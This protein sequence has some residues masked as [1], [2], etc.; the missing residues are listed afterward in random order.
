MQ[1]GCRPPPTGG[2]L[3]LE[4]NVVL[5]VWI[6]QNGQEGPQF[7]VKQVLDV[8]VFGSSFP[9]EDAKAGSCESARVP[10]SAAPGR[11]GRRAAWRPGAM[12]ANG[13]WQW[14]LPGRHHIGRADVWPL[15][16]VRRAAPDC[17]NRKEKGNRDG[18]RRR[19]GL[20]LGP[21]DL[22]HQLGFAGAQHPPELEAAVERVLLRASKHR[23]PCGIS[24][25]T[26]QLVTAEGGVPLPGARAGH[27][28]HGQH[29]LRVEG[30][31]QILTNRL[32]EPESSSRFVRHMSAPLQRRDNM[33]VT[34]RQVVLA[35]VLI[36]LEAVPALA[37]E[38]KV[39]HRD[40]KEAIA[41]AEVS[42]EGD[43][44]S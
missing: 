14:S 6:P 8:G 27:R 35:L 22:L 39:V 34:A 24:V 25:Y 3:S 30:A 11:Q 1:D 37:L 10:V 21:G 16:S 2:K 33:T 12:P 38:G 9:C 19:R 13:C 7:I 26:P 29:R 17:A 32:W 31:A 23:V 42:I 41:N 18:A 20:R 44:A 36:L 4:P 28:A 43:L 15:D 40:T 5:F